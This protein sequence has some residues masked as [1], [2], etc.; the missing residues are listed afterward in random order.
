MKISVSKTARIELLS[1]VVLLFLAAPMASGQQP[2][3]TV[4]FDTIVKYLFGGP[5]EPGGSPVIYVVTNRREWKKV[6]KLTHTTFP[7]RPPLPEID[8]SK[9]SFT[10]TSGDRA[11][12]QY[13]RSS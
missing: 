2:E 9:L 3:D 8:F 10:S 4:P 1:V 6:W 7:A 12:D 5:F 11:T 13:K